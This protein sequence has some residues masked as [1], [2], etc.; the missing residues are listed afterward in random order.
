MSIRYSFFYYLP[1]LEC[2]ELED[3][4][5]ELEE[6]LLDPELLDPELLPELDRLPEDELELPPLL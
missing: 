4:P 6:L 1:P 2:E 5:P 3:E